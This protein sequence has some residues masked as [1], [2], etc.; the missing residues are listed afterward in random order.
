MVGAFSRFF[1]FWKVAHSTYHT[2]KAIRLAQW[3]ERL[4]TGL[5][6]AKVRGSNPSGDICRPEAE[7]ATGAWTITGKVAVGHTALLTRFRRHS[8]TPT[9][10]ATSG[11]E[12]L[13]ETRGCSVIPL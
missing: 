10:S 2:L 6:S 1:A 13:G 12:T 9:R 3:L 11:C 7:L 5:T 8:S 4:D